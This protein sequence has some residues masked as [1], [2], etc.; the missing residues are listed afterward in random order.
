MFSAFLTE[1]DGALPGAVMEA[2]RF[3]AGE[4][5]LTPV[6]P[7]GCRD[8]IVRTAAGGR[9]QWF[10]SALADT[11]YEVPCVE[12][13]SFAGYRFRPGTVVQAQALLD[14][15]SARSDMDAADLLSI[16]EDHVQPDA[17]LTEALAALAEAPGI[18]AA[19]RHLGVSERRL[20][21]LLMRGTGRTPAYWRSL[22]RARRAARALAG[23]RPL[24]DIAADAGY[25]DQAHLSREMRRW[26]GASP[27]RLRTTPALLARFSDAG[28]P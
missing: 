5:L 8:L 26:F 21:R 15:I 9:P 19:C 13:E 1:P 6:M 2:W 12:G 4:N 23:E 11:A 16:I 24:V 14:A 3:V 22:A 27:G 25:A 20:E 18:A 10:I 17:R 28:Y 7:D